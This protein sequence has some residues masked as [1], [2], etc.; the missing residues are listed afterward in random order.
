MSIGQCSDT[1]GFIAALQLQSP[2][3]NPVLG[4][5]SMWSSKHVFPM[6]PW[7]SSR[8]STFHSPPQRW[9]GSV[10]KS[11]CLYVYGA[12]QWTPIQ[13]YSQDKPW[14]HRDTDQEK[15]SERRER[16]SKLCLLLLRYTMARK[17]VCAVKIYVCT[18][19]KVTVTCMFPVSHF[20]S[21]FLPI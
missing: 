20:S 11:M 10:P 17:M 12:L 21:M 6:S 9:S 7:V 15:V 3:F 13:V 2:W 5:L 14:I 8:F 18:K 16:G 4:L 1:V 19:T